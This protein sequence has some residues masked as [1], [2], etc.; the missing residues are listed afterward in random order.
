M[1]GG[2]FPCK[3]VLGLKIDHLKIGASSISLKSL[4]NLKNKNGAR[5]YPNP[6]TLYTPGVPNIARQSVKPGM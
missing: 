5:F 2:Q 6:I 3:F 4:T 1:G